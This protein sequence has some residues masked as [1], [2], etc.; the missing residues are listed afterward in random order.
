MSDIQDPEKS[1]SILIPKSWS[2]D[3]K[4]TYLETLAKKLLEN[5]C[6][7][8]SERVRFTGMEIDLLAQHKPSK[9][10]V[11]VEC[12]FQSAALSANIIDL[13][14][15]QAFRRRLRDV[16]LFSV[17]PLSKEAKGVIEDLRA[18]P[19]ISFSFYGPDLLLEA[20]VRTGTVPGIP[21]EMLRASATHAT[22]L[23]HPEIP[24]I[25]LVQENKD[26]RPHRLIPYTLDKA[27]P[28]VL[29]LRELLD[30]HELVE[31]LPISD[32]WSNNHSLPMGTGVKLRD[33]SEVV[34]RVA[35]ADT[36][37]D[38]RPCRP[39][40]FIGRV[41]VQQEIW[42]HLEAVRLDDTS[43][44]LI[45]IVGASGH[46]KS[47]LVARLAERFRNNKWKNKQFLY[48][49]DVRSARGP[50]FIAE[51]VL[52]AINSAR[53]VGFI[54]S[55][56]PI[57]ITNA[58]NILESESLA[59]IFHELKTEN[60][61]LT[62]FFDQFEEVFTKDELLPLFRAFRRFALDAHAMKL[63]LV[64]GFSWRTG[65]S[66]SD[67]NPAYQLWSELRDH[68]LTIPLGPFDAT[69]SSEIISQFERGLNANLL[70]PLRRKIQEQG[71][72]IPWFLKKLCIHLRT[73]LEKGTSQFDLLGSKLK[74]QALFDEDLE[75]LTT[76]ENHCL[77]YIAKNSPV[78]SID[79]F[80]SYGNE[81]ANTL[82]QKRLV[83]RAGS[84]LAIYWDVFRDY[85]SE[86]KI[87]AIPWTYIP[88][89]SLGMILVGCNELLNRGAASTS[90]LAVALG[91]SERTAVNIV[92]DMQNLALCGKNETGR[93]ILLQGIQKDSLPARISSQ[94][95]EH[96]LYATLLERAGDGG[97]LSR[98]DALSIVRQLYSGADVK[99]S[100]RD[101]Y[102]Q[103][104]LPWMEF[105]GLIETDA[106][107]VRVFPPSKSASRYG[108]IQG[109]G[110]TSKEP[111]FL[112]C[113]PPEATR[114]L[115]ALVL[116]GGIPRSLVESRKYRNPVSDLSSLGL[117]RWRF[118]NLVPT[119]NASDGG[120]ATE[121]LK[122]A[123]VATQTFSE[124]QA[125]ISQNSDL[126]RHEIGA[127]LGRR[128]GK[129]WK[130][131]SAVR[132]AN[133]LFRYREFVLAA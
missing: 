42:N 90:E 133:G 52:Q 88:N 43:T 6:Y 130:E 112:A 82:I 74:A 119:G 94:F 16:A 46:G 64:V 95:S 69:E 71:Q 68:R 1:L 27:P 105:G 100:T 67:E 106:T 29:E 89:C 107:E 132:Y 62:V 20:L 25:W 63:N 79:V 61:I 111:Q 101:N 123:V 11:Y 51:A 77:R 114:D 70:P 9:D 72:G 86:G 117:A 93:H 22:L 78:D 39:Q 24:L 109:R 37:F 56:N 19:R 60:R 122:A 36:I 47:S 66:F 121:I 13:M 115:L 80:E 75:P 99:P 84:R 48:P 49:V 54:K 5:Q 126:S 31:G 15:G 127:L 40:D 125:I 120:N 103:K 18:D 116:S 10:T 8:I 28:S 102:L 65:I 131:S 32:Y 128:L 34:G 38:P 33:Q 45:A 50:L 73:Q 81:T 23:M 110:R 58:T 44:R 3:Q 91:Y 4:G 113:A 96:I 12:K 35:T 87:P 30:H 83:V 21:H 59:E 57:S 41:A 98:P 55:T 92:T 26:G 104:L 17:G 97:I 129:S 118:D 76:N 53:E 7:E 85:L 14:I 124:L 108:A 2:N